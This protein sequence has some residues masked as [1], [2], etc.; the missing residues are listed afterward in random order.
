MTDNN[1]FI[2]KLLDSIEDE[3]Q[4]THA[5]RG[6]RYQ[7]WWCTYKTFEVWSTVPTDFAVG[8]EIKEDFTVIDSLN[9]PKK[10]EFFQIKK[11]ERLKLWDIG[12]LIRSP[13]R[14]NEKEDSVLSKLYSRWMLFKPLNTQM[15]F[16]T[17]QKLKAKDCLNNSIEHHNSNLGKDLH[18]S[19]VLR[20]STALKKQL[21][22]QESEI[23]DLD[24]IQF[25][26]SKMDVSEP[27]TH[28]IGKVYTLNEDYKFPIHLKNIGVAVKY[29]T[30]HFYQMSSN[31][32]YA[33]NIEQLQERCL[34][35]KN[36]EEII[37][38]IEEI[39]KTPEK[40]MEEGINTLD[41]EAYPYRQ[42]KKILKSQTEVL[43]DLRNR[44]KDHSQNLFLEIHNFYSK[45]ESL[46][47]SLRTLSQTI[48]HISEKLF[49]NR[50]YNF[51]TME[52]IKCCVL[53]YDI[54]DG[55]IYCE[56]YFNI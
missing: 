23:L 16:I 51:I 18:S 24:R 20:I 33:I 10:I 28:V 1:E 43:L 14:K 9:N 15:Y 26:I 27:E 55:D 17:N 36:F 38:K 29:I 22:I 31:T 19:E 41:Q 12:D 4:G 11:N 5:K 42:R 35:R 2:A 7:D 45:N 53:I 3:K 30:N 56:Q 13:Q 47:D 44:N 49:A 34:T 21:S 52:Y 37:T 8:V 39:Y 32:N 48:D 50:K 54:S 25:C 40:Y 6:F 46:L